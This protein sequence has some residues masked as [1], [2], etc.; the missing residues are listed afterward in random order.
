MALCFRLNGPVEFSIG[1]FVFQRLPAL[2]ALA[3]LN[4]E[5]AVR[6]GHGSPVRS[7]QPMW[8]R[9]K[10]YGLSGNLI[11]ES[12]NDGS[13][14]HLY[15]DFN[16]MSSAVINGMQVGAYRDNALNQEVYHC[17]GESRSAVYG[18]NGELLAEL[19]TKAK[20]YVWVNGELV[21]I[22]REGTF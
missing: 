12:R 22:V 15:D 2:H 14:Q 6:R 16:R 10:P 13:R 5:F 19:G 4:R 1:L 9:M 17:C 20:N 7:N 11:S 21:G 18:P 8:K 3:S